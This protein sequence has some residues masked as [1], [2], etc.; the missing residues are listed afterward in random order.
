MTK[1]VVLDTYTVGRLSE[2]GD[3]TVLPVRIDG[4]L[5]L[6]GPIFDGKGVCVACAE[7]A[8]LAV[9]GVAP[10]RE[11]RLRLGGRSN[12]ALA[13]LLDELVSWMSQI[14]KDFR[15]TVVAVRADLAAVSTHPVRPRADGC[16]RCNP[17]PVD[18]AELATIVATHHPVPPGSLRGANDRTT[19][20]GLRTELVDQRHG[21]VTGISRTGHL[22]LAMTGAD[23]VRDSHAT[24]GGFGRTD[25]FRQ[26]ERV[27]L[28][29]AVERFNGMRPRRCGT[30][31]VASFAELGPDRA[32]DPASVGRHDPEHE[33][34][35]DFHL[36][37]YHPN[38]RMRWVHGWSYT[39]GKPVATP[40]QLVYWAENPGTGEKFVNDTSNGCGLGNSLV[41]AV[42]HGLFEVAER[43]AFLMAW[44]ARTP[45][46]RIR[47]P[48][49][50]PMLPHL[51]DR[52]ESLGYELMFFDASNDLGIPT[53]LS[54]ALR[55]QGAT[56]RA[57][58]AAGA[59]LD[60]VTAIRSAATEVVVDA[61]SAVDAEL[62]DPETYGRER[63][64]RLLAEPELVRSMEDHVAVNGLA[65]AVD[66]YEYLLDAG[67]DPIDPAELAARSSHVD[68]RDVLDEQVSRLRSLGLEVIA[69]D[70][71]DS[72]SAER[73]GLHSA[74]VIVPGTLQM[75][76]GQ[77]NR[78]T[79]GLP[80][81][82]E[83]PHR[84][85]R[86]PAPL[87]YESLDLYPHP[88]P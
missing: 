64:L 55:R 41:E 47:M 79:L 84:L 52:M 29:E 6:L 33:R 4:T 40:E 73:L 27:A 87:N 51:A 59:H 15:A 36:V 80:R 60:P 46:R 48:A 68:L 5:I 74:K 50:D 62:I 11:Q 58:F 69:V 1:V 10:R 43:D 28:F 34:H 53:V 63:L 76:F 9:Q 22:P 57:L 61:E 37:P 77:L 54:L 23:L 49:A 20:D 81:L 25:D 32:L 17:L 14:P 83:T 82:L 3:E 88:F 67:L 18:S 72:I 38:L 21:P 16:P 71:T 12:P 78:R 45:L 44:Y 26:S 19:L 75:T 13:P 86:L 66:R 70:Q 42:L 8:R 85:G 65:E 7:D 24:V 2:F 30:G 39:N 35:R 31:L 56:R